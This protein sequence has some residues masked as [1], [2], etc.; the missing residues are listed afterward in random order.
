MLARR[1]L[2]KIQARLPD[3][4]DAVSSQLEQK[5]QAT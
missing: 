4:W 2:L 3:G 1:Q 5:A